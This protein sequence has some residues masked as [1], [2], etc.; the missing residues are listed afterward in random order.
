MTET[1]ARKQSGAGGAVAAGGAI[2]AGV[3]I[4]TLGILQVLM[5]ILA[6]AKDDVYADVR[7]YTFSWDLTWW[8]WIHLVIGVLVLAAGV[9][10]LMNK[11]WAYM[12]GILLAVF[13][14]IDNFLFLPANPWWSL[15]I[16]ALDILVIW[17]LANRLP[18][19]IEP[20]DTMPPPA[21]AY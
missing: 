15:I 6:I 19:T 13:S 14:A 2:F 11:T 7:G 12:T 5:G 10:I 16:I 9:G 4:L 17:S 3:V 20:L 8:G 18:K 1:G 21:G